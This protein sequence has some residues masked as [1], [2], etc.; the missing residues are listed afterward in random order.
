[1]KGKVKELF[2][3]WFKEFN[4][5]F[6]EENNN[7]FT[8][9]DTLPT[10]MQWGVFQDFYDSQDIEIT[11]DLM[12]YGKRYAAWAFGVNDEDDKPSV[13][14]YN[15]RSEAREAALKKAEEILERKLNIKG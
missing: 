1:M 7:Y 9:F 10:S 4:L 11:T 13:K 14:F 8:L 12:G 5:V 6:T 2:E 3:K 15:S